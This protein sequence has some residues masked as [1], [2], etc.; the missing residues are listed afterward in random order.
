MVEQKLKNDKFIVDFGLIEKN[1]V[2]FAEYLMLLLYKLKEN[3]SFNAYITKLNYNLLDKKLIVTDMF[4]NG[5]NYISPKGRD[6]IS[7]IVLGSQDVNLEKDLEQ[8]ANDLKELFPTGNKS[9]GHPWRGNT[10]E[11]VNK[12]KKFKLLY[13]YSNTEIL[14]ATKHYVEN[15]EN[16]QYMRVLKYFILKQNDAGE[17]I[18]DLASYIENADE[19]IRTDWSINLS[20]ADH[21]NS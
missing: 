17:Q 13:S 12:L 7:S 19:Q 8:L 10:K 9:P 16:N 6:F 4:S 20:G 15:M 2:S 11:I 3:E 18:S 21:G 5:E 14:N 1:G